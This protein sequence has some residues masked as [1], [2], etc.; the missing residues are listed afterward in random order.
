MKKVRKK[1]YKCL[2]GF[3]SVCVM[4][5]SF[6][7]IA[8]ADYT[9]ILSSDD[10]MV[11]L[12][13]TD[14]LFTAAQEAILE[15]NPITYDEL[16]MNALGFDTKL[17]NKYSDL[18]P[19]GLVYEIDAPYESSFVGDASIRTFIALK[20]EAASTE[21]YV[22]Q[23]DEKL[24]FM[25]INESEND[26]TMQAD[27]DGWLTPEVKVVGTSAILDEEELDPD[28]SEADVTTKPSEPT[29][30]DVEEPDISTDSNADKGDGTEEE[31]G[32][33]AE[34]T[35]KESESGSFDETVEET[36]A[37][38][39]ETEEVS[40]Q[41]D[42]DSEDVSE[43][44]EDE[45][46]EEIKEEIEEEKTEV[47]GLSYHNV[48][49]VA[50]SIDSDVLESVADEP[51][52]SEPK[53]T[54]PK[55][56]EPKETEPKETE[57][58]ETS[59]EE[60]KEQPPVS[61]DE[62]SES[63][64]SDIETETTIE[65]DST[66]PSSE[67]ETTVSEEQDPTEKEPEYKSED[68]IQISGKTGQLKGTLYGT[69][70]IDN[71]FR[72]RAFVTSF[73][74]L[75]GE[76][77]KL[78]TSGYSLMI[79]Q[80]LHDGE[81]VY[82]HP[83]EVSVT[84]GQW[85]DDEILDFS[86]E[87]VTVEGVQLTDPN[88]NFSITRSQFQEAAEKPGTY[89]YNAEIHYNLLAGYKVADVPVT[90]TAAAE[91]PVAE[92][93]TPAPEQAAEPLMLMSADMQQ[94]TPTTITV[95]WED[96]ILADNALKIDLDMEKIIPNFISEVVDDGNGNIKWDRKSG[97]TKAGNLNFLNQYFTL[98][99]GRMVIAQ[100]HVLRNDNNTYYDP[101]YM[102][103]V[104]LPNPNIFNVTKMGNDVY[105]DPL[106]RW[107]TINSRPVQKLLAQNF[108]SPELIIANPS[109]SNEATITIQTREA[110][111]NNYVINS[112]NINKK[113]G[114]FSIVSTDS[115]SLTLALKPRTLLQIPIKAL[116]MDKYYVGYARDLPTN[117]YIDDSGEQI[118]YCHN[119]DSVTPPE[120]DSK[121]TAPDGP[122]SL[123]EYNKLPLYARY[124][125]EN[126]TPEQ[127]EN[128]EN[129]LDVKGMDQD[130]IIALLYAGY[131]FDCENLIE[132][133]LIQSFRDMAETEAEAIDMAETMARSITQAYLWQF[134]NEA[135]EEN[136]GSNMV[137]S[138]KK[139]YPE[140]TNALE[141]TLAE[142]NDYRKDGT[143]VLYGDL[144]MTKQPDGSY[145][146]GLIT[147]KSSFGGYFSFWR[148]SDD[149]IVLDTL[150][151]PVDTSKSFE[152]DSEKGIYPTFI[153][154]AKNIPSEGTEFTLNLTYTY[155]KPALY[156]Y[157]Y[158]K[159]PVTSGNNWFINY[160]NLVRIHLTDENGGV[161]YKIITVKPDGDTD[162]EPDPD[163]TPDPNPTPDPTP[164][165]D[166]TP[167]PNPRPDTGG[168]S[169]SG[170]PEVFTPA[171][172]RGTP[173]P[174]TT[175][176]VPEP[177]PLSTLP[178]TPFSETL[179]IIDDGNV[180]LAALPKTGQS[181]TPHK[182]AFAL[183]SL[184]L[185]VY[186]ILEKRKKISKN[187]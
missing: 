22:V 110:Y 152:I 80:I 117:F 139:Q 184:L 159:N 145:Q 73:S 82:A 186:S 60:E 32:T 19:D 25:F 150:G 43:E 124:D 176:I 106:K 66:E 118:V 127:L 98:V 20:G 111:G 130:K 7:G 144:K 57:P 138:L 14:D 180:P 87:K 76:S 13:H 1:L 93:E 35:E 77:A 2:A 21:N 40:D 116:Y 88:F 178:T 42:D 86:S 75:S 83:Y 136:M 173:T 126:L 112:D 96:K 85:V 94:N 166:P 121:P 69:I 79:N 24:Y 147:I 68:D 45:P 11:A 175:E 141:T 105:R 50:S 91:T 115:G 179:L 46:V 100:D 143:L 58:K 101:A 149:I 55:E 154:K 62:T 131:P 129:E 128:L 162:I 37:E 177:V 99:D 102:I 108:V 41:L 92:T 95:S 157:E 151:N 5:T 44:A 71:E 114:D 16:S 38:S 30:P 15:G 81:T 168:S 109:S 90:E 78:N 51:V 103:S 163:P 28:E 146:T 135:S 122:I 97:F 158:L 132:E 49:R 67:A 153:F 155:Q 10:E 140:Y 9:D 161:S 59:S 148:L 107:G 48:P 17:E 182:M 125:Y 120:V 113:A 89:V 47:I 187:N 185:A 52:E 18:F 160:Q 169:D 34:E 72:A 167:R 54:E 170:G 164:S 56:T 84:D 174:V 119:Y 53:E 134:S 23:G 165:P 181:T 4:A 29:V 63:E 61:D 36:T 133:H 8:W 64:S 74:Q 6:S 142:G 3:L 65:A 39:V 27:V 183:A 172:S 104:T 137:L 26:L 31:S 123:S 156:Y 70:S 12:F 33:A 171:S